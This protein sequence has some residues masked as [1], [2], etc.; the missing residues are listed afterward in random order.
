MAEKKYVQNLKELS[1]REYEQGGLRK[2][3]VMDGS[4]LGVDTHVKYGTFWTAG[5]ILPYSDKPHVHDFDQVLLFA[6]SDMKDIGEL[7]A[8]VSICLGE[9]METHIITT[10]TTV[11]IPKGIPHFPATVNFL[12][13]RFFYYEI[14]ITPQYDEK[15][16][17]TDN[18]P[19]PPAGWRSKYRKYIMPLSFIRKGAWHYGPANRDDGGGHMAIVSTKD[20]AGFDFVL[21]YESMARAPYRIGP[22]PDNPHTHPTTQIMCF[23]GTDPDE[24]EDLGAEFEICLGEEEERHV[25]T[26]ST[27]VVT[28]PFLPHWPGGLLKM[29]RPIIMADIHPFGNQH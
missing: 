13:L 29:D 12:N 16:Y 18:V 26:K 5:K 7:G 25:F 15:P 23:L 6:G 2:E 10:T 4:Y 24:P 9:E 11:A 17:E 19:S 20:I 14:S 22:D 1:F 27:A 3:C 8:E 21:L 28:P